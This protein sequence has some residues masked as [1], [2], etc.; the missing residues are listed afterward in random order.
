MRHLT[1][2]GTEKSELSK[3]LDRCAELRRE[4]EAGSDTAKRELSALALRGALRPYWERR[5]S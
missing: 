1:G 3:Q 5:P 4:A 2:S